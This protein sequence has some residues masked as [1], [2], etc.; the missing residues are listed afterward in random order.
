MLYT[1]RLETPLGL[2]VA[3]A[4]DESLWSLIFADTSKLAVE[5][6]TQVA[7]ALIDSIGKELTL[8][9][10][11]TLNKFKTPIKLNGTIFQNTVWQALQKIPP[12]QTCSYADLAKAINKPTA[13]R[14]VANANG[15]NQFPII[16]PC[17]RVINHNGNLGGYSAGIH[18][19]KWLIEHEQQC[20]W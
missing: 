1:A 2:M 19:K 17:H 3:V 9:F 10:A 16:I 12:G 11:G 14:A 18:R 4:D 15:A 6:K 20:R 7:N 13:C 5:S 8:Y